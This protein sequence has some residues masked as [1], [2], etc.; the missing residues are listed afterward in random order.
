M[1]L[2]ILLVDD[3]K[4][5]RLA[6]SKA[7]RRL[8]DSIIISE[9]A[10]ADAAEELLKTVTVDR[11][12]I[13]YNMPDRNGLEL[14]EVLLMTHPKVKQTLVTANIQ[15]AIRDR[16]ASLGIGFIAKPAKPEELASVVGV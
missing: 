9:A 5:S 11:A 8:D 7:L 12:L 3:S 13:D 15:D 4:V 16:A 2:R 1:A 14:A 10:S 6:L